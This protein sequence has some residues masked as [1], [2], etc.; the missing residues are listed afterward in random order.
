[1]QYEHIAVPA[2]GRRIQVNPDFSLDVPDEPIIPFIEGDGIGI[3]V[4]PAMQR[5]VDAAVAKAYGSRRRIRWMEVYSG[6][7]ANLRY[8]TWF[9]DETLHALRE[10]VVSIKGPLG[11]PVGGGMRSLN[12]AMRQNLDLYA[13]V[14]PIRY[15]PGVA[16]PMQDASLTDM[17]VF[18]ENTED[19]YAG[20]EWPAG[21][22]EVHRLIAYLQKE[23]HVTG[24]RFPSSSGIGI[25][26]VSKEGSQ[27]LIHRGR[28][29][30]LGLPAGA[31]GVRRAAD[32]G[33]PVAGVQEPAH[34]H[35]HRGEGRDC[36]Q[37]P[38]AGAAAAGG[39]RRHRDPEPQR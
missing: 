24:I 1:L 32:R 34:R 36:G 39:I 2:A 4:T 11:T 12:V 3:D 13:C 30:Q 26:P 9:P 38:A 10:F 7:K 25:K 37:L 8:G 21:S 6:E 23:L 5:V 16:S 20:I 14:R 19:I 31:G 33:G 15:F 22:A 35:R 29:P 18:R 28:L 17:V 27:R